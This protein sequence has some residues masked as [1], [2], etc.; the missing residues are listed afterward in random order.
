MNRLRS[1]QRLRA[2]AAISVALFHACQWSGLD[3]AV[4]AAGVDIFFV[5]SGLVLWSAVEARPVAPAAFLAAF[6]NVRISAPVVAGIAGMEYR[7]FLAF[8]IIGGLA[9]TSSMLLL[10]YVLGKSIH[11][12]DKYILPIVIVI[13]VVS[14]IPALREIFKRR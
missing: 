12:P 1:I 8:N 11:D 2:V 5:I 13:V 7:I 3:L 14:A 9:W 4:G 10:G 6:I